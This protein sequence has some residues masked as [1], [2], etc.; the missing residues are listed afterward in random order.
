MFLLDMTY[1]EI[2][3]YLLVAFFTVIFTIVAI[4]WFIG[5]DNISNFT[6]DDGKVYGVRDLSYGKNDIED[7]ANKRAAINQLSSISKKIDYLTEYMYQNNLPTPE[8]ASRLISRWANCKLR[9]TS[10][11]DASVAFTVN[12]GTEMRLCIRNSNNDFEDVNTSIFVVLHELAHIMSVSYGHNEEFQRNFNYI[13]HLASELQI[14]TPQNFKEDPQSYCNTVIN[15]T[16]CSDGSCVGTLT[17]NK[18]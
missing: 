18:P 13:V 2:L 14:Y 4:N 7:L 11:N 3:Y 6:S 10:S 17:P 8:I 15:T 16:P 12:K 9:E 1:S 5:K